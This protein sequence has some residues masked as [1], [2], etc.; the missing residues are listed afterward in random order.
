MFYM[1]KKPV[2]LLREEHKPRVFANVPRKKYE[3]IRDEI[4]GKF[5]INLFCN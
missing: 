2:L 3:A 1:G 5:K 4:N